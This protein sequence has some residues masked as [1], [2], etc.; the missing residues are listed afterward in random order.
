MGHPGIAPE[1]APPAHGRRSTGD[2]Y[3]DPY[4]PNTRFIVEAVIVIFLLFFAVLA[5]AWF[6]LQRSKARAGADS[7]V[8]E[9][10]DAE[11]TRTDQPAS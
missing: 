5:F 9:R 1:M 4:P 10:T 3:S 2:R 8:P 7:S 6:Y 11:V